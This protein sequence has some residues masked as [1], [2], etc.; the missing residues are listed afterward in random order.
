MFSSYRPLP[1]MYLHFKVQT[2]K[3]NMC[4]RVCIKLPGGESGVTKLRCMKLAFPGKFTIHLCAENTETTT[5]YYG[6]VMTFKEVLTKCW[7]KTS[8]EPIAITTQ[9]SA[10]DLSKGRRVC[11]CRGSH[12]WKMKGKMSKIPIGSLNQ[13][14]FWLIDCLFKKIWLSKHSMDHHRGRPT[15]TLSFR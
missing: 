10:F 4:V 8:F 9:A 11:V 14:H 13:F 12:K 15:Q 7:K 1:Y 2:T 5:S 3:C 6:L